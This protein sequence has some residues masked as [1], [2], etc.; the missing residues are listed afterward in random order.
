MFPKPQIAKTSSHLGILGQAWIV[1]FPRSVMVEKSNY[2][3]PPFR[4][5]DISGTPKVSIPSPTFLQVHI[6]STS[7]IQKKGVLVE[8]LR[9]VVRILHFFFGVILA[10]CFGSVK[11]HLCW[12]KLNICWEKS[13]HCL[14][15]IPSLVGKVS[16]W[17]VKA[18]LCWWKSNLCGSENSEIYLWFVD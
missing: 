18:Y 5:S 14:V 12:W 1:L 2:P 3:S 8:T 7:F 17:M 15:K 11:S 6:N 13:K 4:T 16:F 9:T 10:C